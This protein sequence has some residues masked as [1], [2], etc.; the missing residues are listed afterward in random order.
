MG[1]QFWKEPEKQR[2]ALNIIEDQL[3]RFQDMARYVGL[4][5]TPEWIT[6]EIAKLTN[7]LIQ[8]VSEERIA[9]LITEDESG[10]H[11]PK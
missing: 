5:D 3:V 11:Q 7:A 6:N 4:D 1:W 10:N 2:T 8:Q 9:K